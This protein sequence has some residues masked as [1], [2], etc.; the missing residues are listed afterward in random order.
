MKQQYFLLAALLSVMV[1]CKTSIYTYQS[2]KTKGVDFSKYKTYAFL[3]TK[4]TA[5]TKLRNKES[6]EKSLARDVIAQLSSKG[7]VMDSLQPDCLFTYTLVIN[8]SQAIGQKPNEVSN[9]YQFDPLYPGT[10]NI[11]YYRIDNGPT[12]YNGNIVVNTFRDGSL[13][14]DMIDRKENKVIWRTSAQARQ[15]EN[16]LQGSKTTLKEV[17]P[18][19]F[20]K[21]PVK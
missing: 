20:R 9:L 14:I 19:M 7:M 8:Q 1:G 3:P 17:I 12:T 13:V 5:Y 21:F 18:Q 10:G 16:E 15:N 4:D 6:V 2:E 11:Y